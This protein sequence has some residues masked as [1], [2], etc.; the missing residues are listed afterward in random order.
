MT[1][2]APTTIRVDASALFPFHVI[3]DGD[4]RVVSIGPGL[5]KLARSPWIG[6]PLADALTIRRPTAA[7]TYG[8]IMRS[9][10]RLFIAKLNDLELVFRGQ[11]LELEPGELGIF[12][13]TPW[14][15]ELATLEQ[16]GLC[17]ADFPLHD[18]ISDFLLLLQTKST[19]LADAAELAAALAKER[20]K[21]EGS[22]EQLLIAREAAEA[23]NQ[24]KSQFLANMSHE[25]RTPMNGVLG[26]LGLLQDTGLGAEQR[27]YTDVAHAS[28]TALLTVINDILDFSKIEAGALHLESRSFDLDDCIGEV[29]SIV[30][31][32]AT[33]NEVE[34]GYTF[35]SDI[36]CLRGD[37]TRLKQ[38]LLNLIGNAVKFT[39][40][41]EVRLS[42]MLQPASGDQLQLRFEITDTGIGIPKSMLS[43]LFAPFTQA[44]GSTTRKFGG[45]GLG[46]TIAKQLSELMGGEIGVRSELGYGSTFWFTV[47]L[48]PD[49]ERCAAD[50][51]IIHPLK[52]SRA[53]V[54]DARENGRLLLRRHLEQLGLSVT[55]ARSS[56]EALVALA[57]APPDASYDVALIDEPLGE[58][59][60]LARAIKGL[61]T[62]SKTKTLLL[63]AHPEA[64]PLDD[65]VDARIAKPLQRRALYQVLLTAL[66]LTTSLPRARSTVPRGQVRGVRGRVLVAEDSRVNQE[67]AVAALQ[68]LGWSVDVVSDGHA[69]CEATLAHDYDVVLMDCQMPGLDGFEATRAI[70]G[71]ERSGRHL[72][73]LAM[74]ANAMTGDREAC[75]AAG[76]DGY[77][78][79]PFAIADLGAALSP[80]A[81]PSQP[82]ASLKHNAPLPVS[83]GGI[84]AR[85]TT[86]ADELDHAVVASMIRAYLADAPVTCARLQDAMKAKDSGGV[87]RLAH[88]LRSSSATVG[89]AQLGNACALLEKSAAAGLLDEEMLRQIPRELG[90]AVLE[91][92][93]I[94]KEQLPTT[95][96]DSLNA[97]A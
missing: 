14:V 60:E 83:D 36:P 15:T 10:D 89:A 28:A 85:L 43:A 1:P 24:A 88:A 86:L 59:L 71:R 77:V 26:M 54:V 94:L 45:T 21:L 17:L 6:S 56:R 39:R 61:S 51:R 81:P 49:P 66:G 29:F 12:L 20:A 11:M 68:K 2:N 75:L 84:R 9:A 22:N 7:T 3:F 73:I 33:K 96:H 87:E 52:G 92:R 27:R 78:S 42:V 65:R 31:E 67:V 82:P 37:A 5:A 19:A 25:I 64:I 70:R 40:D 79:K 34:L 23:A 30:A 8:E 4:L 18:S 72:P 76:M 80:Y 97:R 95:R 57:A 32:V 69:A 93:A 47:S 53:L 13:A 91:L 41:G 90:A 48:E 74:T 55:E 63:S 46:L 35:D 38:I 16:V 62:A 50:V 58:A 44:D